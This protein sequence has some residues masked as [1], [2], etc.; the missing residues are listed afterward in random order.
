MNYPPLLMTS[1]VNIG[2][3]PY[4]NMVDRERRLEEVIKSI[5][6]W[7][8]LIPKIQIVLVDGSEFSFTEKIEL[9]GINIEYL[10]YRNDK[11][12]VA[13]NGKGA[14]EAQDISYALKNSEKIKNAGYFMKCTG[15]RWVNNISAFDNKD[16]Y[17]HFKCKP[18]ISNWGKLSYINTAFFCAH[19]SYYQ[20]FFEGLEHEVNDHTGMDLEHAMA[21]RIV[22]Q[23]L[24][25]Y[26]FSD[27]PMLDGWD[28]TGDHRVKIYQE[29][30]KHYVRRIKY[31]LLSMIL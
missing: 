16:L 25:N 19:A 2:K 6:K 20:K 5:V 22:N 15:K 11:T 12:L 3:V 8:E 17:S 24:K 1:C 9:R 28:G 29:R 27:I 4:T 14:G 10:S 31:K 13:K 21:Q 30:P 23:K 26:I 18:I 7:Q